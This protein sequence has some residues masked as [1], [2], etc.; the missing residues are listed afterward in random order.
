MVF[1]LVPRPLTATM[2]AIEM[3]AAIRPYSMAVAPLSSVRNSVNI[4]RFDDLHATGND[5]TRLLMRAQLL[6]NLSKTVSDPDLAASLV[7]RAADIQTEANQ[8]T[9]EDTAEEK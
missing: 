3:P 2:I 1:S 4:C 7:A 9:D 5:R 8:V 6:L